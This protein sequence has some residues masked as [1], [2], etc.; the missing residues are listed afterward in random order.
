MDLTDIISISGK[1]G[2]Y[3]IVGQT[4]NNVIVESLLDGKR[5]PTFSSNRISALKDISIYTEDGELLLSDVFRTIHEK[6]NG[7]KCIMYNEDTSKLRSYLEE[8]VPNFDKEQVYN[9]DIKKLFQW[10]NI[11]HNAKK[12]KLKETDK[13]ET[14]T[15]NDA[16]E[17]TAESK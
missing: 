12:L 10:Y 8:L 6:E 5:F 17:N 13:K 1:S 9:S 16:D 15:K 3:T 2:L 11:L 4:K 14:E 7:G